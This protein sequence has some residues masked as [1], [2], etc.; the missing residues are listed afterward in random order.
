M[1]QRVVKTLKNCLCP[2]IALL[3][4]LIPTLSPPQFA[5]GQCTTDGKQ[6]L[7]RSPHVFCRG[8][9]LV[10]ETSS[11]W[12][13]CYDRDLPAAQI[14]LHCEK[15][16]QRLSKKWLSETV[17][18][19]WSPKCMVVLHPNQESYLAAVGREAATTP[20]SSLVERLGDRVMKRRIDLRG[21]RPDYLTAALPHEMTHV[22][23]ADHF[24]PSSLPRWADEGMALLADTPA[25]KQLHLRDLDAAH[26]PAFRMTELLPLLDYPT[27]ERWGVF[28]GQSLSVVEYLVRRGG[29]HQFVQ[30]LDL[31]KDKGYDR[32]LHDCYGIHDMNDLDQL[33]SLALSR[34]QVDLAKSVA[35][36][37]D[38]RPSREQEALKQ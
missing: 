3:G 33:W 35:S 34:S 20:G 14:V 30:F 31:A 13:C 9:W 5:A 23:L 12:V 7:E 15:L 26:T 2:T 19:A 4:L 38:A 21:D 10:A 17:A 24:S 11:F 36:S 27:S 18:T 29:P 32:A 28:Y 8:G 22:T 25:K 16:H 1:D 37:R 6:S